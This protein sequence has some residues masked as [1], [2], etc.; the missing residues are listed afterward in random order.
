MIKSLIKQKIKKSIKFFIDSFD[1]ALFKGKYNINFNA[2]ALGVFHGHK[3]TNS[4]EAFINS[5]KK[6]FRIF[7]VDIIK[8]KDNKFVAMH[9]W[10]KEDYRDLELEYNERNPVLTQEEYLGRRL[11]SRSF[12]GG[13]TPLALENIFEIMKTYPDVTIMFDLHSN[14][15]VKHSQGSTPVLLEDEIKQFAAFFS[16]PM[17]SGRSIIEVYTLENA[18]TLKDTGFKNIQMWIQPPEERPGNL[19][20][21]DDYITNL[22]KNN[23]KIVSIS[24]KNAKDL[25]EEVRKLKQAGFTV[26]SPGWNRYR[27]LKIA[28]NIGIDVITTDYLVPN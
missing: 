4:K 8:T 3:Y 9:T 19:T 6:G 18:L 27:D 16:D 12:K 21:I 26:F 13:L 10:R 11:L 22:N 20:T 28:E 25:P 23:I 15:L 5:Y 1:R 14:T 17:I 2:H 24:P 7:E